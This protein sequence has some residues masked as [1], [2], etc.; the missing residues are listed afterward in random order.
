[1]LLLS[2]HGL[3]AQNTGAVFRPGVT[4][5]HSSAQYRA[6][7]DPDS[8]GFAQR[9]H[10]QQSLNGDLMWRVVGGTR[11]TM[12]SD[13]DPDFLQAELFW[14]LSED[15]DT[16]RTGFRFDLGA[17]TDNRPANFGMHWTNQ[18]ALGDAW[19]ARFIVLSGFDF[20]ENSRD[21]IFL[22]TRASIAKKL[23]NG[24]SLGA[25]LYNFYGST[26]N[27]GGFEEQRHQVGPFASIPLTDSLS[28]Y[29]GALFGVSNAT[30][31]QEL[32]LWLTKSF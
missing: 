11:K 14:E 32:R 15:E 21:G 29:C 1:M 22:Q 23:D 8:D 2:L 9:V 26:S 6:T 4:E 19:T 5:G 7:F 16:W 13:F 10:Y 30:P 3:K 25:E 20:G 28:V 12:D 18:I 27:F 31:D 24:V 17:R